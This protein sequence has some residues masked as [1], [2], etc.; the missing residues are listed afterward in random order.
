[1]GE[2]MIIK[3][4]PIYGWGWII[5]GEPRFKVPEPFSIGLEGSEANRWTGV[6]L[7]Q[8]HEFEGRRVV[9]SQRHVQ[10][11]GHVNVEV[12][13]TDPSDKPSAGFGTLAELPSFVSG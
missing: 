12:Q 6:V 7:D 8:G 10:W 1:M 3:V 13:P 9:L 5:A 4:T 11:S 2:R